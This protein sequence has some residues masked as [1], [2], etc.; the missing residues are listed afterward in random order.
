[1][2]NQPQHLKLLL[3]LTRRFPQ[4]LLPLIIHHLLHHPPRLAVQVAQLRVL[5][6]DLGRINLRRRRGHMRPPFHLIRLVQMDRDFFRLRARLGGES[7]GRFVGENAKREIALLKVEWEKKELVGSQ[8][9]GGGF[10]IVGGRKDGGASNDC[11][12]W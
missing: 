8:P 3:L 6:L 7:P 9:R 10:N 5:R 1:M 4:L 12:S 2:P 11:G